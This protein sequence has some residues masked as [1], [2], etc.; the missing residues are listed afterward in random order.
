MM[1]NNT[2]FLAVII[3]IT[4]A[5]FGQ[6]FIKKFTIRES[7]SQ[8][9]NIMFFLCFGFASIVSFLF[10][11]GQ[12]RIEILI[13]GLGFINA[14][15]AWLFWRAIKESLSQTMLFLPLT[16]FTGVFLAALFLGEWDFLNP[17]N[18]GGVLALLGVLGLLGSVYFFRRSQKEGGRIKKI[19]L[20]CIIGQSALGGVI[21]FLMKYF[22]LQATAKTDFIFSWYLGAWLGS[23]ILLISEKDLKIHLPRKGLW[24]SYLLL[25]AATLTA[26]LTS[27]WSLE[28]APAVLVLPIS[29]F[30]TVL[31]S[32]LVGLFI[33]HE[34]KS[35]SFLDWVGIAVGFVSMILLIGGMSLV[36]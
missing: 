28:L 1:I 4:A 23:F 8:A 26:V 30:F 6:Y 33:F 24:L 36:R 29:Q 15:V 32:A 5:I 35:F 19:W 11:K 31:G 18:L 27:Y 21:V 2:V 9:L 20:W 16:G 14:L 22:A 12:W 17:K 7:I 25:S 3:S 13:V 10:S 34:R